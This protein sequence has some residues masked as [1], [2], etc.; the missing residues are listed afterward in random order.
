MRSVV[1][2]TSLWPW[3][4]ENLR[5]LRVL[6]EFGMA[7][8]SVHHISDLSDLD[9]VKNI[10]KGKALI[11]FSPSGSPLLSSSQG[12][13][14]AV[15]CGESL[16]FLDEEGP[17]F[18][19]TGASDLVPLLQELPALWRKNPVFGRT[20][21]LFPP[22]RELLFSLKKA[23]PDL[24]FSFQDG[25]ALLRLTYEGKRESAKEFFDRAKESAEKALRR[26]RKAIYLGGR[27]LW[28]EVGEMLLKK[29][30]KL[31]VAESCTGG[32][33]SHLITEL[34]GAS[35]FFYQGLVT[36]RT[37]SK[38]NT[39]G[40]RKKLI[41]SKGVLSREVAQEM[42]RKARMLSK[43]EIGVGVTGLAG[44]GGG[45]AEI[46]VGTVFIAVSTEKRNSARRLLL[47]GERQEI[48]LQ[49]AC[50]A[51]LLLKMIAEKL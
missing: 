19:L 51:L 22:E 45:S 33:L 9:S 40:I 12:L 4:R 39:L 49:S 5:V 7:W 20:F 26:R 6:D 14:K 21:Y 2:F 8:E 43:A 38:I 28:E 48:K 11:L 24:G 31:A 17:V 13:E 23:L 15:K 37:E 50:W 42:A 47:K 3:D 30:L 18:C 16:L 46:P 44:P 27:F 36:Y 25:H 34:P 41:T 32:L 29:K 35:N 10:S 1:F